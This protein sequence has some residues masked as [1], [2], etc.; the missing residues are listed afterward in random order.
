MRDS[1][2]S[3][4][5]DWLLLNFL[6]RELSSRHVGTAGGWLWAVAQPLLMLLIY[7]FVFRYVFQV[8]LANLEGHGFVG[9]LA[10]ALWPWTAFQEGVSRGVKAVTANAGLVRKVVFPH[11]LLVYSTVGAA[12]VFHLAGYCV[13]LAG[14]ALLGEPLHGAGLPVVAAGWLILFLLAC[15]A[16]FVASALQVFLKDV[17]QI[18]APLLMVLFYATPILYPLA[19]VPEAARPWL[20]INPL[21][22]VVEPLRE[23]LLLGSFS[24]LLPMGGVLMLSALGFYLARRLFLRLS[25]HFEDFV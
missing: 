9:F 15:A 24:S 22:H 8:R 5:A 19:L 25:R 20:A 18:V 4:H 17:D 1:A 21:L 7:S 13:V 10:C 12:F 6:R 2:G 14:L 16:A 23:A 3:R 11:Q